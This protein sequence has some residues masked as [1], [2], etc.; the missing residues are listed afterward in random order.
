MLCVIVML[1]ESQLS[2]SVSLLVDDSSASLQGSAQHMLRSEHAGLQGVGPGCWRS[3][4]L[5][6]AG[7]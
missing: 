6:A 5:P 4:E 7:Q 1:M 3:A 2:H